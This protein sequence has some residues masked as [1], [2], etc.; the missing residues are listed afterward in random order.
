MG[1]IFRKRKSV[2]SK[3]LKKLV[4]AIKR[5]RNG[6]RVTRVTVRVSPTGKKMYTFTT[7]KLAVPKSNKIFA[8]KTLAKRALKKTVKT[9]IKK[10]VRKTK[11][12]KKVN[13]KKTRRT[14]KRS[15]FGLGGMIEGTF[16]SKSPKGRTGFVVCSD[17]NDPEKFKVYKVNTFKINGE[18]RRAIRVK[19]RFAQ[20]VLYDVPVNAKFFSVSSKA[21]KAARA[22]KLKDAKSI[23]KMYNK[24]GSAGVDLTMVEC[25]SAPERDTTSKD[26]VRG[27]MSMRYSKD[28]SSQTE[29][30]NTVRNLSRIMQGKRPSRTGEGSPYSRNYSKL[31]MSRYKT[32]FSKEE[33]KL[34]GKTSRFGIHGFGFNG[35]ARKVN[36]GFSDYM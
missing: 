18:S 29:D 15:S 10:A 1:K 19:G 26:F 22:K 27:L 24:L 16:I 11:S 9:M 28:P 7:S 34:F 21:T 6:S 12:S 5:T 32:G 36:Y 3:S 14:K 20:P 2:T 17:I 30:F 25:H 4:Y 8:N 33:R 23:A 31:V 13:R 35:G